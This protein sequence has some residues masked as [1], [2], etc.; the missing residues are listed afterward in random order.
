MIRI[1]FIRQEQNDMKKEWLPTKL[2]PYSNL[3]SNAHKYY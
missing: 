2:V 3:L 1:I